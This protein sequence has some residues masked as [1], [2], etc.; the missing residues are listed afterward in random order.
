MRRYRI[1]TMC[2]GEIAREHGATNKR[3]TAHRMA[4]RLRLLGT[5]DRPGVEDERTG[6]MRLEV[7]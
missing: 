1:V 6:W 7:D 3:R 5:R 4:A 2:R